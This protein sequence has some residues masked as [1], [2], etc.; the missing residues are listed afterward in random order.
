MKIRV[1]VST[2]AGVLAASSLH[3]SE[4]AAG[5]GPFEGNVGN[6]IWTLVVFGLVVFV[7]GKFAWT[8]ILQGLQQREQ[9]IRTSLEQAKKDR[10][11]AEERLREYVDRLTTARTEATAIVEEA[12]RDADVVRRRIEEEAGVEA[13]KI[14]ERAKR[15]I[16]IARQTAVKELFGVAARLTTDVASKILEREISP[17]DH[18][19]LI[20]E[21]LAGLGVT[22]EN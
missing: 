2:A 5:A 12:R 6:A 7:L 17:A 22:K 15:E 21:S 14:V 1:L 18:E 3:A 13:G 11:E 20:R 4:S 16:D 8:P 9:F 19:R 10:E